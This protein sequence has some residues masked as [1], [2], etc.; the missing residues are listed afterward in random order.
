MVEWWSVEVNDE[1]PERKPPLSA[2]ARVAQR[3][4]PPPFDVPG[5]QYSIIPP[6]HY[7][8]IPTF[9]FSSSVS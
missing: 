8:N 9:H 5:F 3:G 1:P 7:S 2:V 6:F 4:G